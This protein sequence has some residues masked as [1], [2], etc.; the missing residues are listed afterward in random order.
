ML[1]CRLQ[2]PSARRLYQLRCAGHVISISNGSKYLQD[3]SEEQTQPGLHRPLYQGHA[4]TEFLVAEAHR[5]VNEVTLSTVP[6]TGFHDR[7]QY[8]GGG[9]NSN[10]NTLADTKPMPSVPRDSSEFPPPQRQLSSDSPSSIR[11][12]PYPW[13]GNVERRL[14]VDRFS[15]EDFGTNRHSDTEPIYEK[16]APGGRF[17][18]FP[19]KGRSSAAD[20]FSLLDPL[21]MQS[22]HDLG[23]SFASSIVEALDHT[24]NPFI[25]NNALSISSSLL[26]PPS[27]ADAK[28]T[29][30]NAD[31]DNATDGRAHHRNLSDNDAALLAYMTS[32]D[33]DLELDSPP[34]T[35]FQSSK[36]AVPAENG[37]RPKQD[38][39]GE[40]S[41]VDEESETRVQEKTSANST[42]DVSHEI[43]HGEC[44]LFICFQNYA[45]P[46]DKRTVEVE[47]RHFNVIYDR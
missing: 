38:R 42:S 23:P 43:V 19:V 35:S 44:S 9:V 3:I 13:S 34:R 29:S 32:A 18:T 27:R 24:E 16:G 28:T 11:Q 10:S 1:P 5:A 30:V 36:S 47:Q 39:Y 20:G 22:R 45:S 31:G 14:S 2:P 26:E 25:D 4:N 6:S 37:Q 12:R 46:I 41:D 15:E 33:E 17:A 8:Y 21:P 7:R 40:V